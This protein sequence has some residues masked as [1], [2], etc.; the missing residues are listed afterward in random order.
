MDILSQYKKDH[1]EA[2]QEKKAVPMADEY[3]RVYTG[4]VALV[5][6]LSGGRIKDA[7]TA[8]IA[9]LAVVAVIAIM[10]IY[11]FISAISGGTNSPLPYDATYQPLQ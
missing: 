7:R 9:L 11:F 5:M 10:T 2:F 4:M 6:R 1:P 8:N 3:G